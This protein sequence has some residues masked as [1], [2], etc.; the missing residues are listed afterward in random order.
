MRKVLCH[1]RTL[2]H[3]KNVAELN[4]VCIG[5]NTHYNNGQII[6]HIYIVFTV[7]KSDSAANKMYEINKLNAIVP[8]YRI[9]L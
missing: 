6:C 8:D 2:E 1:N 5:Y 3:S 9:L 7:K 4:S